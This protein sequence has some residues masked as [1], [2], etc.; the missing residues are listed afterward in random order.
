LTDLFGLLKLI[1]LTLSEGVNNNDDQENLS[2]EQPPPRE[3]TRISRSNGDEERSRSTC[4][5]PREGSQ[6]LD[7]RALLKTDFSLPKANR[8]RKPAEF[9]HVYTNGKRYDGRFVSAFILPNN[10]EENRLGITASRKGVGKAVFR[11]RAKRLLREAFRLSKI[12]LE[13]LQKRYDFVL[14]ARRGLLKVKMQS[15]LADFQKIIERV[16]Q[17]ESGE[18]KP[19][20]VNL[21][22]E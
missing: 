16:R 14:N 9:R 4:P 1:V 15:P 3:E 7:G 19:A 17:D 11:N 6:T 12:E 22:A 18:Q 21:I 20:K 2:T 8:L 5:P 13:S 10:G